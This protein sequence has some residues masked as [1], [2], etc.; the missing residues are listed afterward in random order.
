M[1]SWMVSTVLA[2]NNQPMIVQDLI[3]PNISKKYLNLYRF[4]SFCFL[5]AKAELNIPISQ[6]VSP[7][8]FQLL[9]MIYCCHS[10]VSALCLS[11][12]TC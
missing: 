2:Q 5:T 3:S 9:Y 1:F 7:R 4:A 10:T 8:S 11:H 12:D 6:G